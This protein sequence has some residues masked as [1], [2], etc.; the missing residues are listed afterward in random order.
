MAGCWFKF[1]IQWDAMGITMVECQ[2][3]FGGEGVITI[4]SWT[5]I[6]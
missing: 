5:S 1:D 3:K 2:T 6:L 4:G